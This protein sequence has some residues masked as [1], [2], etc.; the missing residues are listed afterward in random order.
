M[1]MRSTVLKVSITWGQSVHITVRFALLEGSDTAQL[2]MSA[3]QSFQTVCLY[4][5]LSAC[6]HRYPQ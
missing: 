3:K 5:N 6:L 2:S 1:Y 4:V